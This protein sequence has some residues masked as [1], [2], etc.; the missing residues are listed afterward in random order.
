M[1]IKNQYKDLHTHV[2][3]C[4]EYISKIENEPVHDE[5]DGLE[6]MCYV[7]SALINL[8]GYDKLM[9]L[10]QMNF[11]ESVVFPYDLKVDAS[12]KSLTKTVEDFL[13]SLYLNLSNGHT[14]TFSLAQKRSNKILSLIT[15]PESLPPL[16]KI[17]LQEIINFPVNGP[18][19]SITNRFK[20]ELALANG[21][22]KEIG[23]DNFIKFKNNFT[24]PRPT[25]TEIVKLL[26][27]S[28]IKITGTSDKPPWQTLKDHA[29]ELINSDHVK[30]TIVEQ[31]IKLH[32][33]Y[34][35]ENLEP[36]IIAVL[37]S[38]S[39][40][41]L[42]FELGRFKKQ[43]ITINFKGVSIDGLQVVRDNTLPTNS[44]KICTIL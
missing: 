40:I 29:K 44:I 24:G 37:G 15:E 23:D 39:A 3:E 12:P 43:G 4:L 11:P 6:L 25:Q 5:A 33:K 26:M 17:A 13:K 10:G 2:I 16:T 1:K 38:N 9:V 42:L 27:L 41:E 28:Y 7:S 21:L 14:E 18:A 19:I 8:I 32:C 30:P 22:S 31:I 34:K 20:L 36:G 35:E